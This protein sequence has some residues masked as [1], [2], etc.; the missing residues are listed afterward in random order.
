MGEKSE[1]WQ[2]YLTSSMLDEETARN[3][4]NTLLFL[5][6]SKRFDLLACI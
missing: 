5:M 4:N 6:P 2:W 3:F 1:C